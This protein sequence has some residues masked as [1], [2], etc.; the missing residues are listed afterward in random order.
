[1]TDDKFKLLN[2]ELE[3][4]IYYLTEQEGGRKSFVK[5]GYRGQFYYNGRDWDA[6]QE[7][8][9]KEICN[10]GETVK[11]RLQTLSPDFHVGQFFVGQN[12]ETREGA[13]TVGRGKITQILRQDFNYWDFD[14]F[15]DQLPVDCK[16]YNFQNIGGFIADF[17]YGLDHIK[18][19]GNL[20]FTKS[21]SDRNQMLTVE[22]KVKDKSNQAR[23]L[24][25][26]I[27]KSW[28]EEIQFKNSF[29][30]TNLKHF[31]NGFR[32]ELAF[33]TFHSMYLTGKII[34]N[35]T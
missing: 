21:L 11:V 18:Q 35:T 26:E 10:P 31:D 28:R 29:Y 3:G 19:I 12:F 33:A 24:I 22:C 30:K 16:P 17:E 7:F 14:S 34:L 9:D 25:D 15:F 32:F 13:K 6:P 1:M 27:C 5:S 2:P 8:I 4:E 23:P 20:K